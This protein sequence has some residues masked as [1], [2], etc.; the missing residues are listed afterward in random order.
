MSRGRP[1]GVGQRLTARWRHYVAYTALF[2]VVYGGIRVVTGGFP[3]PLLFGLLVGSLLKDAYDELRL[4]RGRS[5]LA[6]AGFEHAP[7]NA[8]LLGFL[9][10]GVIDPPGTVAGVPAALLAGALAAVDLVV[11]LSQDARS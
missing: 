2:L 1:T 6:Y 5:P 4:R 3:T 11:D 8:V 7:S 10:T 9:A